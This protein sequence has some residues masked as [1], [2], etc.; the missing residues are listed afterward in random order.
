MGRLIPEYPGHVPRGVP[1][2]WFAALLLGA[3]LFSF[4]FTLAVL[5]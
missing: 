4:G 5:Q 3:V 1:L 2:A